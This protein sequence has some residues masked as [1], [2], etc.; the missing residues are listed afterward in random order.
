MKINQIKLA[1][2]IEKILFPSNVL[3]SAALI[4]IIYQYSSPY[5]LNHLLI[6]FS[7]LAIYVFFRRHL[8]KK[9]KNETKKFSFPALFVSAFILLVLFLIPIS[10]ELRIAFWVLVTLTIIFHLVRDKWK[11]SGHSATYA[12]AV[13]M[14]TILNR[15]FAIFWVLLP[16]VIWSRLKL[17]RHTFWQIAAGILLGILIPVL[18]YFLLL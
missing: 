5:F 18:F 4:A 17:K 9:I 6:F 13:T 16:L 2:T 11:I 12:A 15:Y 3:I 14:L 8:D 7:S 1:K 10:K